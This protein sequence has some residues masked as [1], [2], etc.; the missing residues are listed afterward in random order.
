MVRRF[1]EETC[2]CVTSPPL[3]AKTS[4]VNRSD[5]LDRLGKKTCAGGGEGESP[6][7]QEGGKEVRVHPRE[8]LSPTSCA[9][10]IVVCVCGGIPQHPLEETSGADISLRSVPHPSSEIVYLIKDAH[11]TDVSALHSLVVDN[12]CFLSIDTR[13]QPQKKNS[14]T[15]SSLCALRKK[16]ATSGMLD[17]ATQMKEEDGC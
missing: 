14:S 7:T 10:W 12:W 5:G 17:E 13:N 4:I 1:L 16:K 2:Y 6:R 15:I 11:S 9:G 3:K 8:G